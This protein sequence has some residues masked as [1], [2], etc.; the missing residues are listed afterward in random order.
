LAAQLA[1][2]IRDW[3]CESAIYIRNPLAFS[4]APFLQP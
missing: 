1:S 3:I 4:N 2:G